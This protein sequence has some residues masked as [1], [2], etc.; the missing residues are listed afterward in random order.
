MHRG[1]HCSL[2]AGG[3]Y[4]KGEFMIFANLWLGKNCGIVNFIPDPFVD[5]GGY[6]T[7]LQKARPT[8]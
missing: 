5:Q 1:D 3:N 8:P 6:T 7:M 2:S 4:H